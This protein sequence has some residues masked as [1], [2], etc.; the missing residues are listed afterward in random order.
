MTPADA[1]LQVRT[2]RRSPLS[3]ARGHVGALWR[4]PLTQAIA[5]A[6]LTIYVTSTIT[7]GLIRLIGIRTDPGIGIRLSERLAHPRSQPAQFIDI[8]TG[9]KPEFIA[10]FGVYL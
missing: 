8:S 10:I 9:Q 7:F 5:K 1:T 6:V 3:R 2:F 4:R